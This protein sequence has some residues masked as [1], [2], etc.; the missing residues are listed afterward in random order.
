MGLLALQACGFIV[1]TVKQR[2]IS[3]WSVL[4]VSTLMVTKERHP[5]E[6]L[7]KLFV[8]L[9]LA[10]GLLLAPAAG[11]FAA[12]ALDS[13]TT[14]TVGGG[15]DV[16]VV[17]APAPYSGPVRAGHVLNA[18]FVNVGQGDA[19]YIELPNGQ[20]VLIDGG[21]NPTAPLVEFLTQRGI[22]KIDHV[23]LTHP[24][25]DHYSGLGYVFENLQVANFYD[26][27]MDNTGAASAKA[28]RA[29]I[30]ELGVNTV[31]PSEG[32]ELNWDP[33]VEVKVLHSCSEPGE[34]SSGH[35]LNNC[36]I[37]LKVTYQD[38][39]ILYMGDAEMDVEA[40][41]VAT[42]GE[43]LRADVLKVGHHG[44]PTSSSLAFLEMVRPRLAYIEVGYANTFNFPSP[45]TMANLEAVGATPF[46][47]YMTGTQLYTIQGK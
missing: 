36:S 30:N 19:E 34:S 9:V 7:K 47:T 37:V 3:A 33:E 15:F 18:Y 5:V 13:L 11:L 41:L 4:F 14:L 20:N 10:A 31:Y 16:P 27:R 45:V 8:A 44:S 39:S 2:G 21:P 40:E 38:S 22:T 23:V 17:P 43:T 35:V 25:L 29:R 32:D 24:H 46:L 26:T 6:N 28:L 12:G 42:Y 1:Y